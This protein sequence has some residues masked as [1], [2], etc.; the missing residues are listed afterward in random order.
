[1][2]IDS[3]MEYALM[4]YKELM[5]KSMPAE[6]MLLCIALYDFMEDSVYGS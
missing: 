3:F 6:V 1:M 4:K 5:H 2:S